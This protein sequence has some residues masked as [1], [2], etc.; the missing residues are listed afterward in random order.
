MIRALESGLR[1]RGFD[2]QSFRFQSG[3]SDGN[4]VHIQIIIIIMF[5]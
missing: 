5:A 4:I 3:V 1:G 2:S